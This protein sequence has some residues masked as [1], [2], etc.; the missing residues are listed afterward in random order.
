[1]GSVV[2]IIIYL[3]LMTQIGTEALITGIIFS[4]ISIAYY[5]LKTRVFKKDTA[6]VDMA[7]L[8][9][10][11]YAVPGEA[12]AVKMKHSYYIWMTAGIGASLIALGLYLVPRFL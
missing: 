11:D 4:L 1:M 6:D 9:E 7:S 12:E 3:V 2:S 10:K 8:V 5:L